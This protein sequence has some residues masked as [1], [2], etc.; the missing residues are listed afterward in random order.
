[1]PTGGPAV[2]Q[3]GAGGCSNGGV[4]APAVL[5]CLACGARAGLDDGQACPRCWG[6]LV[7]VNDWAAVAATVERQSIDSGPLSMWRY[8]DLLPMRPPLA[9]AAVGWTPLVRAERL[10]RALGLEDLWLKDE[11]ANPT[12]S[13]KDRVVAA[14]LGRAQATGARIAATAS[15]GNLARS[16]GAGAAGA[17]MGAVVLVPA[18]LDV[19]AIGAIA[20]TGATVLAVEGSYD[21]ANRLS[22]EASMEGDGVAWVNVT[23]RAWYVEGAT[24]VAYEIAEQLGWRCPDHVLA[25]MASG[26]LVTKLHDGFAGLR[27]GG[28]V[29]RAEV[30][31]SGAQPAGCAPIARAF[32]SGAT[33]VAPVRP[34]TAVATLAMGDPPEGDRVLA[35]TRATGGTVVEVPE[36]DVAAA[37]ALLA[38]TEGVVV[39][40]AGGV[41]VAALARMADSGAA[42]RG[43]RIVAVLTGAPPPIGMAVDATAFT[44]I[45]PTVEAL[46]SAL[47]DHKGNR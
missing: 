18:S 17:G 3:P 26:A 4:P 22:V 27:L 19:A 8:A 6:Q 34:D 41:V 39:E 42:L 9:D 35:L 2:W 13:F 12:G 37:S 40:P 1:M 24:T 33:A 21:A 20:A 5:E 15:T 25:P 47:P 29:E 28:L 31:I 10:G 43:E 46:R 11:T 38:E 36:D 32:A 7:L 23:L 14:A 45:A 16:L 44:T 30:R